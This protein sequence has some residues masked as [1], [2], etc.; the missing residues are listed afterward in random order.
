MSKI[1]KIN[2]EQLPVQALLLNLYLTQ[3]ITLGLA[4]AIFFFFHQQNPLEVFGN[5]LPINLLWSSAG[6]VGFAFVVVVLNI[7]LTILLPKELLDDGGINEKIFS[8]L[9]VPHIALLS[10]AVGISE[11]LLFRGALQPF[12]GVI[13]TSLLF[14][15]I[16]F[17]YLHKYL[18]LTLTFIISLG[19]G[20][21][22][23]YAGLLSAIIAHSL[24]DLSLG[25]IIKK[26]WFDK[27]SK[28]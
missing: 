24:I 11:E 6:A 26:K 13:G 3:I 18:L 12:L 4:L 23:V 5:F 10:I 28:S 19:L 21:L 22:T 7:L 2:I 25:L 8:E 16:H 27:Y 15:I 14:T 17:R 9:S 20:Y 1:R